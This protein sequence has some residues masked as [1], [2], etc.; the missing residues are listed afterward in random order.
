MF[1]SC[2][3]WKLHAAWWLEVGGHGC[4]FIGHHQTRVCTLQVHGSRQKLSACAKRGEVS[5]RAAWSPPFDWK[6]MLDWIRQLGLGRPVTDWECRHGQCPGTSPNRDDY[7]PV[8]YDFSESHTLN[9]QYYWSGARSCVKFEAERRQIRVERCSLLLKI[10]RLCLTRNML[11]K[12]L[13]F[14]FLSEQQRFGIIWGKRLCFPY[15]LYLEFWTWVPRGTS[16]ML[17]QVEVLLRTENSNQ[18]MDG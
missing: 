9:E 8:M 4:G 10:G 7:V 6:L 17:P 13:T 5:C 11:L 2:L 14:L 3:Q 15:M 1:N 18:D 12:V 16:L